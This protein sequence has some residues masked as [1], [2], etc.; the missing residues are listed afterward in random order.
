MREPATGLWR[1]D[2]FREPHD[3]DT[4]ICRREESIRLPYAEVIEHTAARIPFLVVWPSSQL[5][6]DEVAVE[7]PGSEH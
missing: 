5:P 3:E 1:L 4:W 2:I 6:R 7:Q